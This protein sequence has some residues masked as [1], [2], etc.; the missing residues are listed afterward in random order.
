[1]A[2]KPVPITADPPV[3]TID[4]NG[5]VSSAVEI[6]NGGQVTF[7]VSGYKPGNNQCRIT[8]AASNI[9]WKHRDAQGDNT[10]KVGPG[11]DH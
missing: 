11:S 6:V 3:I 8:I 5:N 4:V 9:G 10:I 7:Q 1:M 2:A